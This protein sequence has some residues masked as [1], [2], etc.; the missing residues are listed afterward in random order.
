[1]SSAEFTDWQAYYKI[2]PFGAERDNWHMGVLA[3]LFYNLR[4][5][6]SKPPLSA[7]DFIYRDPV[8]AR[9]KKDHEM[10]G[11]LRAKAKRKKDGRPRKARRQ[12]G[13]PDA[14]IHDGAGPGE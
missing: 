8:A 10:L 14:E 1:M 6:K 9:Q 4:R 3:A 7:S 11:W 2:E 5:H 13:S 12:S